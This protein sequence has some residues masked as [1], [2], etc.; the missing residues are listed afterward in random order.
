[1]AVIKEKVFNLKM[2]RS[3]MSCYLE[4]TPK[5]FQQGTTENKK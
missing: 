1:M 4:L 5:I 2:Y 3:E